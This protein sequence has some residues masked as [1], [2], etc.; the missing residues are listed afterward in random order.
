MAILV[1]F[2]S[3]LAVRLGMLAASLGAAATLL[4]RILPSLSAGKGRL[5]AVLTTPEN[6]RRVFT[7]L[8]ALSPNLVL[9]RRLVTAYDSTG[10]AL[11]TRFSDVVEVLD[12]DADFAVVYEPKMREI[13]AGSNFFLGMQDSAEYTRDVSNMRLAVRRS[14]VDGI[15]IPLAAEAATALV[16]ACSEQIDVPQQ[17]TLRVPAALLSGYFGTG[18][19]SEAA[20]IAWTTVMFWYLFIDLAGDAALRERALSAAAACRD[21]LDTAISQRKASP[22]EGDDVLNR[23]LRMQDAGLP[24]MDDLGI[25]NNL[26]GLLIGLVP[27]LSEACV[28]ALDQLLDRPAALAGAQA[29]AQANDDAMLAAY[30]FEALRFAPINPI[31]YRR[32]TRDTVIARNTLR[33][34]RVPQGTM[35]LAA[36]LSAMFDPLAIAA[37]QAFRTNRP[38]SAYM[39]WGYGM[40]GCFGAHINRAVIPQILK[41]LLKQPG[42][43]RLGPIDRAGTPFPVHFTVSLG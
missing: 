13:T 37:P 41:P 16:S 35:V 7:I 34:R 2:F 1:G 28:Q 42:L 30:V 19:P 40:H 6:Q 22:T 43:R 24:G 33:Q 18:G 20:M 17:L 26:I 14:D 15:V 39:L 32:A 4:A 23:C 3:G 38:W 21:Y 27:T 29:A 31:I 10:T 11:V 8:R 9:S 36:N 5:I 12:R 25:R